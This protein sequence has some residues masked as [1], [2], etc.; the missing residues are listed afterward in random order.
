MAKLH[1]KKGDLV[2]VMT[3]K[4]KGKKGKTIR[5]LPA[6]SRVIV[7]GVNMVKRHTRPTQKRPQGG[8]ISKEASIHISNVQIVCPSCGQPARIGRHKSAEGKGTRICRRC[9]A[10]LD[11]G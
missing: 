3:G 1:I 2:V 7:E 10:E 8:V 11:K 9:G 5:T 6:N 4:D